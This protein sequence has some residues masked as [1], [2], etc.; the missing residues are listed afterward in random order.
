MS[1]NGRILQDYIDTLQPQVLFARP[2]EKM[3]PRP[4]TR[5]CLQCGS[6]YTLR[7]PYELCSPVLRDLCDDCLQGTI[8]T[9]TTTEKLSGADPDQ[10][11]ALKLKGVVE[12]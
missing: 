6:P 8:T 10:L 3:C 1:S 7:T 2:Y 4:E 5:T 12:W 11:R 9:T